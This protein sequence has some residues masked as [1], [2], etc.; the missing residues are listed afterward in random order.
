MGTTQMGIDEATGKRVSN[1][2]SAI[3]LSGGTGINWG[4]SADAPAGYGPGAEDAAKMYYN[5][6]FGTVTPQTR[7]STPGAPATGPLGEIMPDVNR[8]AN[9]G[10]ANNAPTT[11]KSTPQQAGENNS[12]Y[13]GWSNGNQDVGVESRDTN[14]TPLATRTSTDPLNVALKSA[15]APTGGAT[16]TET[17]AATA[18][19]G[20]AVAAVKVP[21]NHWNVHGKPPSTPLATGTTV[22]SSEQGLAAATAQL[23]TSGNTFLAGLV[24]KLRGMVFG[25]SKTKTTS[26]QELFNAGAL[27]G[28]NNA[29]YLARMQDIENY[30][31]SMGVRVSIVG[32]TIAQLSGSGSGGNGSGSSGGGSGSGSGSVPGDGTGGGGGHPVSDPGTQPPAD[33]TGPGG[34]NPSNPGTGT[35]ITEADIG[36]AM[37]ELSAIVGGGMNDPKMRQFYVE[38]AMAIAQQ[39]KAEA[40]QQQGV[41]IYSGAVDAF[42]NDPLRAKETD[43]MSGILDKPD[44]TPWDIIENQATG[45]S[46]Q[47]AAD[48]AR[49]YGASAARRLGSAGAGALPGVYADAQR[50]QDNALQT[51]LGQLEIQKAATERDAQYRALAGADAL[52]GTTTGADVQNAG[53]LASMVMGAPQVPANPLAGAADAWVNSNTY[54]KAANQSA[55]G[56]FDFNNLLSIFT[57]AQMPTTTTAGG[58]T[59][60]GGNALGA[61]L[62]SLASFLPGLLAGI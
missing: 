35:D 48:A 2:L 17:K 31:N 60:G 33:T 56:G 57:G 3:D 52:R 36:S 61:G 6:L 32:D 29:G 25:D 46:H 37:R 55:S 51:L 5:R 39:H 50:S 19:G 44:N 58:G 8:F 14:V 47:A 43:I 22:A 24:D 28:K 34:G 45:A 23:A 40:N 62:G 21:A 15:P 27:T 30:L 4:P 13:P 54:N 12:V 11:P 26:L 1:P 20:E 9:G 53:A 7:V 38:L 10:G 41:N 18:T 42:K 49:T 59:T 16:T